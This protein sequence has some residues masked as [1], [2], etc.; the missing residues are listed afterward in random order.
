LNDGNIDQAYW[1]ISP[2]RTKEGQGKRTKAP[3][4]GISQ[5][6]TELAKNISIGEE[7]PEA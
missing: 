4:H 7:V 6:K 2:Y 1:V 3:Q 5:T